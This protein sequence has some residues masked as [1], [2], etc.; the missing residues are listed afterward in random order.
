MPPIS[1]P[2]VLA[3]VALAVVL[4]LL[5][6]RA[7]PPIS[8]AVASFFGLFVSGL[9]AGK[10]AKQGPAYHGA[11]VGAGYVLCEALGIVPALSPTADALTDTVAVI[12]SDV[13]LLVSAA[14]GGWSSRL[15]S[16]SDT[17]R[18]R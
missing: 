8:A 3:G 10:R 9:F 13:L 2:A 5:S 4:A 14:L 18:G 16:S 15:W 17:D 11:L 12:A 6:A 7:L 1:W